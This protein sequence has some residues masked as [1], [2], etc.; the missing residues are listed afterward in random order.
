MEK[1]LLAYAKINLHIDVLNRLENGYHN[2]RMIMQQISIYDKIHISVN[3]GNSVSVF[4]EGIESSHNIV[5]KAVQKLLGATRKKMAV[6]IHIEKNIPVAAGLGGGSSDAASVLK[7][8][9]EL[10]G[11][12]LG[13]DALEQIGLELGADVPFFIRG[14]T[15]LAEGIGEKLH[16]LPTCQ[17]LC[18]LLI[19]PGFEVSTAW[20]YGNLRLTS[21]RDNATLFR[22]RGT[23]QDVLD[24]LHNDLEDVVLTRFPVLGSIKEELLMAGADGALMSGSGP[25]VF[26]V[27]RDQ[28][29][30][31]R[32]RR[33]FENTPWRVFL[34]KPETMDKK[35]DI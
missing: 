29:K 7:G 27:F 34:A 4:C 19:N 24:N 2:V 6:C 8:L 30:A 13:D 9:N 5:T 12:N 33:R 32:A 11:F 31:V 1:C 22:Y 15:A 25:T 23:Y 3:E 21:K 17:D 35:I 26:G 18:Y 10:L 14:G 28:E 20:V 16:S